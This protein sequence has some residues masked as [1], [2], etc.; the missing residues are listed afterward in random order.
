MET[1]DTV[2]FVISKTGT[3]SFY[4]LSR[5]TTSSYLYIK[6]VLYLETI[7][8]GILRTSCRTDHLF[9]TLKVLESRTEEKQ[10]SSSTFRAKYSF[11]KR[12]PRVN[13]NVRGS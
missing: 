7:N 13:F 9:Y 4:S 1:L 12:L 6:L 3:H 11:P 2:R 10:Q 8:L 5:G